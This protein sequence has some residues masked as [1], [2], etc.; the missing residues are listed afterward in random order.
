M[1]QNPDEMMENGKREAGPGLLAAG[2]EVSVSE[3]ALKGGL[4]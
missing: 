3:A 2:D 1:C 4:G